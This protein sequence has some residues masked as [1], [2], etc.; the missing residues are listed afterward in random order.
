MGRVLETLE[1]WVVGTL[2]LGMLLVALFQVF[3]R[4]VA[5]TVVGG[6]GE[7]IVVYL[8]VWAAMLACAGRVTK[9][10][11]IRA[12]LFLRVLTP[13]Q[14]RAVEI[15]NSLAAIGFC[16]LLVWYGWNVVDIAIL[17]DER[18]QTGISFPM[19]IYYLALPVGSGLMLVRFV[20]VLYRLAFHP[21]MYPSFKTVADKVM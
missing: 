13:A 18:S 12:D 15:V 2:G 9:N 17:I 3:A 20:I 16:A 14:V 4:Y 8:F 19:W 7:E 5:P 6:G 1:T 11:H 10:G 21:E